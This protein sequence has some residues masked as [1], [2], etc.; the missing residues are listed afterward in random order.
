MRFVEDRNVGCDLPLLDQP[1]Q[2]LGRAIG[3]VGREM[4][5]LEAEALGRSVKHGARSPD[6]RLPDRPGSLHI[7]DDRV[8]GIDQVVG[9]VG[10]EG[11]SLVS[12]GPL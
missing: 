8:L 11:V 6:L 12:P 7:E 2:V 4:P 10:E 3:A 9:R 1:G 5:R